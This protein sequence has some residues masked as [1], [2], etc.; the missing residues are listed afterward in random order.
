MKDLEFNRFLVFKTLLKKE[1]L[2]FTSVKTQTLLAPLVTAFLYLLIFGVSLGKRI[3]LDGQTSYLDFVIPGLILMGAINNSFANVSSSLFVSRYIGNIVEILSTP[4]S[5]LQFLMAYIIAAM[6]RAFIV[7]LLVLG[8]SLIFSQAAW[9]SPMKALSILLLTSF[10][11]ANLGF[12]AAILSSTF[13]TLSMYTNFL[14][15]P[16]I[17]LGGLFYPISQLPPFWRNVSML[18]PI[19]YLIEGFR[20]AKLGSGDLPFIYSFA[21]ASLIALVIFVFSYRLL[22]SGYKLRS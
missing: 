19:Y 16:L 8:V 7:A 2:R 17:Y 5:H 3:A 20:S 9:H 21:G 1:I 6:L 4:I 14:I 18:N 15:L 11:F 10:I 13:D 12:I 22:K